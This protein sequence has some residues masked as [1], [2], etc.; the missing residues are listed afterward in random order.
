[1]G[2]CLVSANHGVIGGVL[3]RET[4]Q[5]LPVDVLDHP[6]TDWLRLAILHAGDGLPADVST[7]RESPALRVGHVVSMDVSA[8]STERLGSLS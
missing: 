7:T 6:G 5:G 3:D 4:R 1:M 2:R 8:T